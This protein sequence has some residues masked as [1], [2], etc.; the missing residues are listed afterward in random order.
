[1]W[2]KFSEGARGEH[3]LFSFSLL[4]RHSSAVQR[5]EFRVQ[6]VDEKYYGVKVKTLTRAVLA[7]VG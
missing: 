1:M 5:A 3:S 4:P 6:F 2:I 7:F